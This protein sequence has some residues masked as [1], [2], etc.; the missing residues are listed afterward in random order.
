MGTERASDISRCFPVGGP[1]RACGPG[2]PILSHRGELST[3]LRHP[4]VTV[5][6]LATQ[7]PGCLQATPAGPTQADQKACT[8]D[9]RNSSP[10]SNPVRNRNNHNSPCLFGEFRRAVLRLTKIDGPAGEA[11]ARCGTHRTKPVSCRVLLVPSRWQ[12]AER[13]RFNVREASCNRII[14]PA[15]RLSIEL[16]K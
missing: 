5:A 14:T 6:N 9:P 16:R 7:P 4:L 13:M 2:R 11:T 15:G 1:H 12:I 3:S 8:L 10:G